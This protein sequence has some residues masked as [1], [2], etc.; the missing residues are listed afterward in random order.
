MRVT[1]ESTAQAD[2]FCELIGQDHQGIC[3]GNDNDPNE[4]RA[5]TGWC[6]S[7]IAHKKAESGGLSLNVDCDYTT[8]VVKEPRR[9]EFARCVASVCGC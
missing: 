7:Q 9:K 8:C 2:T 4:Q 6:I 5:T 3:P 1:F